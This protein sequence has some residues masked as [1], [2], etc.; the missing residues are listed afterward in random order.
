MASAVSSRHAVSG[1]SASS[2]AVYDDSIGA[3][4][5]RKSAAICTYPKK[6]VPPVA[7]YPERCA[8]L[9]EETFPEQSR[10]KICIR[11][12]RETGISPDKFER[13]MCGFTK[14]PDAQLILAVL[15]VRATRNLPP[16]D[17]GNGFVV[18][19]MMEARA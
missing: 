3:Y 12:H 9:I 5:F 6:K 1:A 11:A 8:R 10:N 13:I 18:R 17:L 7:D 16:F 2:S 4:V 15:A 14:S 19:A